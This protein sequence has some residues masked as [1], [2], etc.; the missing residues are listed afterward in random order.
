M[1]DYGGNRHFRVSTSKSL[2]LKPIARPGVIPNRAAFTSGRGISR[3]AYRNL[4]SR[5]YPVSDG[6]LSA[7]PT[8]KIAPTTMLYADVSTVN[9]GNALALTAP[10]TRVSPRTTPL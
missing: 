7:A 1:P 9:V 5:P 6:S 3:A 8:R 10:S 2:N 4:I